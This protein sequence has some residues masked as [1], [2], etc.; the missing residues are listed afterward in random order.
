MPMLLKDA[1]AADL[2]SAVWVVA[3]G[4]S[5]AAPS[6]TRRLIAHYLG[7]TPARPTSDR[8]LTALTAREREVLTLVTRGLSNAEIAATLVL[9]ESTVKTRLGRVL[10]KLDLRDRVQAVILGYECGLA[11]TQLRRNQ[12]VERSSCHRAAQGGLPGRRSLAGR[13]APGRQ[14]R[15]PGRAMPGCRGL[16]DEKA[17]ACAARIVDASGEPPLPHVW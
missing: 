2:V 1:L 5:V 10:T 15:R 12:P 4:E 8:R 11:A 14:R 16:A 3:A 7:R 13:V 6:V 17:R 9:S